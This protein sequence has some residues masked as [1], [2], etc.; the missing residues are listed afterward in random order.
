MVTLIAL[1]KMFIQGVLFK[2]VISK[3]GYAQTAGPNGPPQGARFS[4]FLI[5]LWLELT[6]RNN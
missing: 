1:R 4:Q 6:F 2:A 5:I 3:G